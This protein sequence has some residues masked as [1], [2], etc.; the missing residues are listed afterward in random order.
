MTTAIDPDALYDELVVL[1]ERFLSERT[2]DGISED[3]LR[4]DLEHSA[5][6]AV[7]S[8][9]C[10]YV[11]GYWE[12]DEAVVRRLWLIGRLYDPPEILLP[13]GD[14]EDA[15]PG[16]GVRPPE[17]PELLALRPPLTGGGHGAGRQIPG[18]REFPRHWSDDEVIDRT[19]DVAKQPAGAVE[20]PNGSFRAWGERAGIQLSVI[21]APDGSVRTSYPV[22]GDGVVQ[23]PLDD[24][25]A[26]HVRALQEL[27]DTTPEGGEPRASLDELMAVGEWPHVIACL[28]ALDHPWTPQQQDELERLAGLAGLRD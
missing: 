8:L 24:E 12:I 4:S 20:L 17:P 6:Q 14:L 11:K 7:S 16:R 3:I 18:K 13:A 10:S 25:R 9:L 23:V 22:A 27:L 15:L 21:V 5:G 26:T 28:R 19:M 1:V 2:S